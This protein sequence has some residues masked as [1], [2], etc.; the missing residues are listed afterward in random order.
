MCSINVGQHHFQHMLQNEVHKLVSLIIFF[1]HERN[2]Q[3][4]GQK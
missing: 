1:D 2:F 4:N 3:P